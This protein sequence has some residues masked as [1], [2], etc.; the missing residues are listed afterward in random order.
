[1]TADNEDRAG[2]QSIADLR[3]AQNDLRASEERLALLEETAGAIGWWDWHPEKDE[4]RSDARWAEAFGIDA[5]T[6][7]KGL[8]LARS[9]RAVHPEDR[10][11]AQE[12][13]RSSARTGAAFTEEFRVPQP[14]GSVLWLSAHGRSDRRPSGRPG[15]HFGVAIDITGRKATESRKSA[16]LEL[17]DR[18]RDL[19]TVEKIAYD[20]AEVMAKT[21]KATRAGFGTVDW[22]HETV[23]IQPNWRTAG[24][25][26]VEGLYRFRDYGSF[27]DDLKRGDLVV[28]GDVA[29]DP[30][31]RDYAP[32]LLALGI[33]VL[34]NVPIIEQGRLVLVVF[35]HHDKPH[36]WIEAELNFVRTVADRTQAAIARL[37]AEE[38]QR[39]L[40]AELEHR[41]KNNLAMVHSIVNQTLGAAADLPAGR[42]TLEKRLAAFARAHRL[43]TDGL[44]GETDILAV[45]ESALEALDGERGRAHVAGPALPVNSRA[46][47]ALAL[48]LH[49]LAT[50]AVKYG[51]LS[52]AGGRVQVDWR[53]EDA[54]G[55]PSLR[56]T[57]R[58]TG[59]PPVAPPQRQ[60]FGSLLIQ[61]GTASGTGGEVRLEYRPD[62]LWCELTAPL[63][64]IGKEP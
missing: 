10:E 22:D 46:S 49:E 55:K 50:N 11:R 2:T 18:L 8:P 3:A 43:L 44:D 52:N 54:E 17:G 26:A 39:L 33:R 57:W 34:V 31:T 58:E 21:L 37:R 48:M 47:L 42:R 35:V 15:R 64:R 16:L 19:H 7:A 13:F 40:H 28:I 45:V 53:V 62:G 25:E 63:S 38:Q 20:A 51:A 59:G 5:A 29:A 30:R 32:S 27:I 36:T 14:D 12:A 1:M 60:G 23:S 9:L 41:L 24:T 56:L 4:F 6:A 61:A